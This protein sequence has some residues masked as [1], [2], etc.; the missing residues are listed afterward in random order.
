MPPRP[1]GARAAS[2]LVR[3]SERVGSHAAGCHRQSIVT[4]VLALVA[5]NVHGQRRHTPPIAGEPCPF[6]RQTRQGL[7]HPPRRFTCGKACANRATT[8]CAPTHSTVTFRTR[9]GGSAENSRRFQNWTAS[10][11]PQSPTVGP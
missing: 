7:A 10:L 1:G 8:P 5:R 11:G 3:L 4:S 2:R 9:T 6:L